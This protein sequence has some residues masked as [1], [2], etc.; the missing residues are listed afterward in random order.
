MQYALWFVVDLVHRDLMW[1]V[2]TSIDSQEVSLTS[3]IVVRA[4]ITGST[5]GRCIA[6]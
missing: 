5:P 3:G 2:H 4:S 1:Q 6:G